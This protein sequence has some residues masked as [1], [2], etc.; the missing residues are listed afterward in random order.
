MSKVRKLSGYQQIDNNNDKARIEEANSLL[1]LVP[2]HWRPT[3]ARDH[4]VTIAETPRRCSTPISNH[5]TTALR[6]SVEEKSMEDA[7]DRLARIQVF[8]LSG[9]WHTS[10]SNRL[11]LMQ[12][13]DSKTLTSH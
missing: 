12:G 6:A 5:S 13:V 4:S 11:P 1:S 7:T 3:F 9:F 10:M 2:P 8:Y